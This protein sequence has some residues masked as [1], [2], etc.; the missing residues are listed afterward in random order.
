MPFAAAIVVGESFLIIV[1]LFCVGPHRLDGKGNHRHLVVLTH[2]DLDGKG[3][4]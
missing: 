1:V 3:K 2:P 4:D